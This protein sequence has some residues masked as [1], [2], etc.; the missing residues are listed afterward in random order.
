MKTGNAFWCMLVLGLT[1]AAAP[2]LAEEGSTR[3]PM[4]A[5]RNH[6]GT[7][8]EKEKAKAAEIRERIHEKKLKADTNHD[9]TVDAT[10]KQQA[11]EKWKEHHK[12]RDNNPPGPKGGPGTNWEKSDYAPGHE[13]KKPYADANHDGTVDKYEKKQVR[14][15][16]QERRGIDRDNNPPGPKGGKGTNWE[17]PPGPKGGAGASPNRR[18][19]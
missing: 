8:D 4:K 12:D 6:D 11:I 7:V 13:Y 9:G 17:N 18:K 14:E 2:A 15:N 3:H 1:V 19:K 16:W 10:E 5:D